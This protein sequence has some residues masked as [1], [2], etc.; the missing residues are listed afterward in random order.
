M[1]HENDQIFKSNLCLILILLFC[2]IELD[3]MTSNVVARH[4][5]NNPKLTHEKALNRIR[6]KIPF[7][8]IYQIGTDKSVPI[9]KDVLILSSKMRALI[10]GISF[11]KAKPIYLPYSIETIEIVFEF[12]KRCDDA[13]KR[14]QLNWNT[15]KDLAKEL[16]SL[17][18]KRLIEFC[19][20]GFYLNF[21]CCTLEGLNL[22]YGHGVNIFSQMLFNRI[23]DLTVH[24]E[25]MY[26]RLDSA[27]KDGFS[28]SDSIEKYE[29]EF[30][31]FSDYFL[32]NDIDGNI[33]NFSQPSREFSDL[34]ESYS[35]SFKELL[36]SQKSKIE[37]L[38]NK[39]IS[40]CEAGTSKCTKIYPDVLMLSDIIKTQV[41][42]ENIVFDKTQPILLPYRLEAIR[43]IFDFARQC[44]TAQKDS[45]ERKNIL[46]WKK[47]GDLRELGWERLIEIY[48]CSLYLDFDCCMI[49]DL[50]ENQFGKKKI[51]MF[52]EALLQ[53]LS[54]LRN[55][56][57][58]IYIEID[59]FLRHGYLSDHYLDNYT[60][61]K[62]VILAH[63]KRW[64]ESLN[65]F[66]DLSLL[67][68]IQSPEGLKQGTKRSYSLVFKGKD[69]SSLLDW[70]AFPNYLNTQKNICKTWIAQ[71]NNKY[72]NQETGY[73]QRWF[74]RWFG[75]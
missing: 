64:E 58:R 20:C 11:D 2:V 34:P 62:E 33:L 9:R 42:D 73:F 25:E 19:N 61:P 31:K 59:F 28:A 54:S 69:K 15:W 27:I 41:E 74:E 32:L 12:A 46:L 36:D 63:I 37:N 55:G 21:E 72:K 51:N 10:E 45:T 17:P 14:Q 50:V 7:F 65:N 16:T 30:N 66:F 56:V 48:N 4:L 39:F 57:D 75:R 5:S 40:V 60:T 6:E 35:S 24:G 22:R 52:S 3:A 38:L 49:K 29:D 1:K 26:D 47:V 44:D 70:Q 23:R 67:R 71:L 68:K 43:F 53:K 18:L 13:K 8:S